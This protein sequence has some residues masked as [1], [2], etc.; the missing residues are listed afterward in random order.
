MV[1][2]DKSTHP[3]SFIK[4][5]GCHTSLGFPG[6]CLLLLHITEQAKRV[7][8][9]AG[10]HTSLG[11]PGRCQLL[12]HITEQAKRVVALVGCPTS[13]GFPGRC[14]LLL[15]IIEQAKRVV[16]LRF[17]IERSP[18]SLYSHVLVSFIAVYVNLILFHTICLSF[19]YTF[20]CVSMIYVFVYF[21]I[22]IIF[23]NRRQNI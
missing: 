17:F 20:I 1:S 12:L 3:S 2:T 18:S 23:K 16:P 19:I 4:P 9:L 22:N 10:C 7:V 8:A 11:F 14:Q 6:R 13:L 21:C 15:H 5:A